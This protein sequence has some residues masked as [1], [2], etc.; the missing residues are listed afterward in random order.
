MIMK[1][2]RITFKIT[3][4]DGVDTEYEVLLTFES[5]ETNK[6]Y[7]LYTDNT[8]DEEGNVKVYASIYEP[9]ED[10]SIDPN[11]TL[12]PVESDKEWKIIE[13][14]LDELQKDATESTEE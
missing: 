7:M 12:K 9:K 1:E 3:G 14:I 4:E 11:T 13:T 8:L 6:S 10:G 2:E 5:N